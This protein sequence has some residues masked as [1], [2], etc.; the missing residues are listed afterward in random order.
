[1]A[2]PWTK[3]DIG[4]LSPGQTRYAVTAPRGTTVARLLATPED[5]AATLRSG[6]GSALRA[7]RSGFW[8]R[9]LPLTGGDNTLTVEVTA[10][11][12]TTKTYT[13]TVTLPGE[14]APTA[15]SPITETTTTARPPAEPVSPTQEVPSQPDT[16]S[17]TQ[18]TDTDSRPQDTVD[19]GTPDTDSGPPD[20]VNAYDA[21]NNGKIDLSELL[22]AMRDYQNNQVTLPQL[23]T[24]IR[25]YLI[26]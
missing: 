24:I 6:A 5:D 19:A 2:G 8:S 15:A 22:T 23:Q 16:E 26:N 12:G 14:S 18:D 13:V 1:A 10:E 3:L 7:V 4:P 11:D 25:Y 21:D 20:I 9:G 17:G